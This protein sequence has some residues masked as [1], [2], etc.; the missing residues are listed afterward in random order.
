MERGIKVV[1]AIAGIIVFLF[2]AVIGF[3]CMK[4]AGICDEQEERDYCKNMESAEKL[5][6]ELKETPGRTL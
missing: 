6:E 2:F 1:F 3:S 5:A 4:M